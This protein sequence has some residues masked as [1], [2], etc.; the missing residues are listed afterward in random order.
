[1]PGS[2]NNGGENGTRGIISSKTGFAHTGAVVN[3]QGSDFLIHGCKNDEIV[4][5]AIVSISCRRWCVKQFDIWPVGGARAQGWNQAI[6]DKGSGQ[7]VSL[8]PY[9]A[10]SSSSSMPPIQRVESDQ[11]TRPLPVSKAEIS[12]LPDDHHYDPGAC[13]INLCQEDIKRRHFSTCE[14]C[15][16]I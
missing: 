4:K 11:R 10:I 14:C 2:A 15:N 7:A 3:D 1:M 12:A 13:K 9:M 16:H 5:N 8:L 6:W